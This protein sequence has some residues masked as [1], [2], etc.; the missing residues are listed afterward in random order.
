MRRP[1]TIVIEIGE[2][3]PPGL[4][5]TD[6]FARMRDEIETATERLVAEANASIG[7]EQGAANRP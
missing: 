1:G 2:P 3:I 6:F 4:D 5:R 7:S